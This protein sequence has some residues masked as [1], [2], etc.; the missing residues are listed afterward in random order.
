MPTPREPGEPEEWETPGPDIPADVWRDVR[1]LST[2]PGGADPYVLAPPPPASAR[3]PVAAAVVG[4]TTDAVL[5]GLAHGAII[6]GFF[7]VGFLLS[8]AFNLVLWLYSRRSPYVAYHAQQAGCYQC[9]VVVFNIVYLL[10]FL[11]CWGFYMAYPRWEFVGW[12]TTILFFVG[13]V[14]FVFSILFGVWVAIRV[15]LGKPFAYPV[16]GRMAARGNTEM[17]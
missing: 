12:I 15:F 17:G 8:L 5:A 4:R 3:R 11:L 10:V 14:W 2:P 6:F 1:S 9:F 13:V 7:G 16:F